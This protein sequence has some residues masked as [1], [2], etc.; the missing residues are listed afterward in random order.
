MVA[1]SL[2]A[3][4]NEHL[5]D[6][7]VTAEVCGVRGSRTERRRSSTHIDIQNC[8]VNWNPTV[9]CAVG[10]PDGSYRRVSEQVIGEAGQLRQHPAAFSNCAAILKSFG[11]FLATF[12]SQIGIERVFV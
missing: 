7:D 6:R 9:T 5:N 3:T 8:A 1:F 4:G 12:M 2:V 10:K 11:R